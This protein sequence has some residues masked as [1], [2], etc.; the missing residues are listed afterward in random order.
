MRESLAVGLLGQRD[1]E[2]SVS[3]ID[4]WKKGKGKLVASGVIL[5]TL[6]S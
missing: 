4:S 6:D 5:G 2:Q 3:A 1:P